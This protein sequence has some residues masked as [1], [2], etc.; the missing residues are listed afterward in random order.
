MEKVIKKEESAKGVGIHTWSLC[1]ARHPAVKKIQGDILKVIS[2]YD[3]RIKSLKFKMFH[4]KQLLLRRISDDLVKE[5]QAL[6]LEINETSNK[7]F[8]LLR[9]MYA[10]MRA[11]SLVQ[12]QTV[13]NILP[14]AGRAVVA[15]WITGDNTYDA[16]NGANYGSLGTDNS[17]V[18]NGDTTLGTETYRKATSSQAAASNVAYL[19]NFYTAAE[20][21]GTFEECGWH[22]DGTGSADTG[23]LFSHFLTG[24]I[25]KSATETLTVESQITIT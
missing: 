24:S 25:V 4:V 14:T 7:K 17:A 23:Q 11:L 1:D 2:I 6:A 3:E 9:D 19:S 13:H 18:A 16:A 8:F 15:Q 10:H 22:I 5:R 21:T 20:V 12:Q